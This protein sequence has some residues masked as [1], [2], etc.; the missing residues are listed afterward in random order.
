MEDIKIVRP[1]KRPSQSRHI[2]TQILFPKVANTVWKLRKR[3][4]QLTGVAWVY[5][6]LMI[7]TFFRKKHYI[8]GEFFGH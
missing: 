8:G 7:V 3:T 4:F 2:A 6:H 1:Y 5:L